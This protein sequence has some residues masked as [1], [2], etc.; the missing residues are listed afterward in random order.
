MVDFTVAY[1]GA[2]LQFDYGE[3]SSDGTRRKRGLLLHGYLRYG[4]IQDRNYEFVK[5]HSD[6]MQKH[7]QCPRCSQKML[8]R[9]MDVLEHLG[10]CH[11]D[12]A[13][14]EAIAEPISYGPMP[15]E[16]CLRFRF[17]SKDALGTTFTL[18]QVKKHR[19]P[20]RLAENIFG[21]AL[22]AVIPPRCRL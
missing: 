19:R 4:S 15:L 8:V 1:P 9:R 14:A 22:S 17:S 21:H 7:W 6:H 5:G 11:G 3:A 18:C 12:G 13:A 10:S 2:S 20:R 16:G